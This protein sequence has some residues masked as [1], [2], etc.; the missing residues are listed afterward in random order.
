LAYTSQVLYKRGER[1][2][3]G[4]ETLRGQL[5]PQELPRVI[6]ESLQSSLQG[7]CAVLPH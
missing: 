6:F 2:P 7:G 5:R 3:K 1:Y 4:A